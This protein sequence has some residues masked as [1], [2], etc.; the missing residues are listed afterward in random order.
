MQHDRFLVAADR[1]IARVVGHLVEHQHI[2]HGRHVLAAQRLRE[3]PVPVLPGFE[4]VFF[5]SA[6][7]VSGEIFSTKPSSTAWL[8]SIR[9]VQWSCPSGILLQALAI[10]APCSCPVTA[11]PYPSSPSPAPT[12]P[13]PP[14][15]THHPTP[16]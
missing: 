1:R 11:C 13:P 14:S 12:P 10:R 5:K 6:R 9:R 3:A 8:A 2:F 7:M 15:R 16:P 4:F